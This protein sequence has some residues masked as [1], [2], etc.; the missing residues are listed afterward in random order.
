MVPRGGGTGT[1]SARASGPPP[2]SVGAARRRPSGSGQKLHT[3][4][5]GHSTVERI[6]GT[7]VPCCWNFSTSRPGRNGQISI[8]NRSVRRAC[9]SWLPQGTRVGGQRERYILQ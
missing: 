6:Y 1:S 5:L 2:G 8:R 4:D 3:R 7:L 9:R